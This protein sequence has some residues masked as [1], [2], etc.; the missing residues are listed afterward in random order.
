MSP[1]VAANARFGV[2]RV[3]ANTM[4][5]KIDKYLNF[6]FMVSPLMQ[7]EKFVCVP[8]PIQNFIFSDFHLL[9]FPKPMNRN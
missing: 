4:I 2:K 9:D 8:T 1:V 5:S 6:V 7:N 3:S